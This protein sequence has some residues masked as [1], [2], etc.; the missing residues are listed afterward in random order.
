MSSPHC[1]RI[2]MMR[3]AA[4]LAGSA[5]VGSSSV[6]FG[7][8]RAAEAVD[9]VGQP[10]AACILVVARGEH[11]NALPSPAAFA[12]GFIIFDYLVWSGP[13]CSIKT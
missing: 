2:E 8:H 5:S 13:A 12:G 7:R 6:T 4:A 9:A 1:S 10:V 3:A 11:L